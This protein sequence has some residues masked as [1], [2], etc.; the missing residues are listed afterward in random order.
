MNIKIEVQ[1]FTGRPNSEAALEMVK[2][3][4]AESEFQIDFEE[5]LV[6]TQEAAEKYKFRSSPTI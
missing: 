6:E 2:N 1:H 4:V 3:I 5:I